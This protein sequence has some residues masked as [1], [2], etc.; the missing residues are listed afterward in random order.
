MLFTA[1]SD[2]ETIIPEFPS[3]VS[4]TIASEGTYTLTIAPNMDW[5]L[6]LTNKTDFYIQDGPAKVW[7]MQ[8]KAGEYT[9]KVCANAIEDFDADHTCGVELTMGSET[10]SIAALTVKKTDRVVKVYAAKVEDGAYVKEGGKYV[11]EEN[12]TEAITLMDVF[13][14]FTAPIKVVSNFKFNVAGPEWMTAVAGGNANQ[15]VELVLTADAN[16]LPEEDATAEV[17]FIDANSDEEKVGATIS[18]SINGSS[19]YMEMSFEEA[20]TFTYEGGEMFG[21]YFTASENAD[22]VAVTTDGSVASWLTIDVSEW[23]IVGES[24]Q[25]RSVTFTAEEN[26]GDAN[27]V[28]YVFALPASVTIENYADLFADG[29]VKEEYADYLATVVTQYS[30]PATISTNFLDDSCTTFSEAGSDINF[31]FTEGEL[32]NLYIGSKYD[33]SYYGEWAE[34]GSDSSFKTTRPI[35]SFE[36]YAYNME[37]SF[38][39]IT[40]TSWVTGEVFDTTDNESRFKLVTDLNAASAEGSWNV[41]ENMYEAVVLVKYI[42]GTYSGIYFHYS[43]A[44]NS[45][46]SD[47]VAFENEQYAGWANATLVELHEGD[48]LYEA[49]FAEY[50]STAMPARFYHLTYMFPIEQSSYMMVKLTGIPETVFP[51]PLCEWA[52]YNSMQQCVVMEPAGAGSQTPGVITFMNGMGINEIVILCT[53]ENAE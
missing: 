36:V 28:A 38:V 3:A 14:T 4:E 6:E 16:K 2:D 31:W 12:P 1:C 22:V 43:N 23:I 18:L 27:R 19:E 34:Y 8:G 17:K 47:G 10:K 39:N 51:N 49:Y 53:L 41:L 29:A 7:T 48:E 9:I 15:D 20:L 13:G 45:G 30:A 21:G 40:E 5:S 37:G 32:A 50:S 52:Y 11:Y 24:I 26:E 35:D 44:A 46:S 33:I 42:D 25:E